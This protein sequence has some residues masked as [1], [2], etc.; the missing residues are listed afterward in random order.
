MNSQSFHGFFFKISMLVLKIIGICKTW[1]SFRILSFFQ[2]I[3][4]KNFEV[5]KVLKGTF[6]KNFY[7][8][9]FR[10]FFKIRKLH[11]KIWPFSSKFHSYIF[12]IIACAKISHVS[13]FSMIFLKVFNNLNFRKASGPKHNNFY[14]NYNFFSSF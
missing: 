6:V 10:A 4:L 1:L 5:C 13:Y 12:K 11:F 2:T 9:R 3:K 8:W 7:Y 14:Q